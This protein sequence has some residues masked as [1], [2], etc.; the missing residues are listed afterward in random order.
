MRESNLKTWAFPSICFILFLYAMSVVL[1]YT[2]NHSFGAA[3]IDQ[4]K[5]RG[6]IDPEAV[7]REIMKLKLN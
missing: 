1:V 3:L 5:S 4:Q 7:K 6:E 2:Y